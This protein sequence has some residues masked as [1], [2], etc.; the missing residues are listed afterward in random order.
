MRR[1]GAVASGLALAYV[2]FC[3]EWRRYCRR[4]E[5]EAAELDALLR[6]WP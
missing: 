2:A 4:Y 5:A 6:S 1:A 3:W